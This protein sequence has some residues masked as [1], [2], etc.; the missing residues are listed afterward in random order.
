MR[1]LLHTKN[2]LMN[3]EIPGRHF[4]VGAYEA[5]TFADKTANFI[6]D[7]G[8]RYNLSRRVTFSQIPV[9]IQNTVPIP[10]FYIPDRF[11]NHQ[12]LRN[13]FQGRRPAER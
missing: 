4:D 1:E 7:C 6:R 3:L 5:L 9:A 2:G 12:T 8:T 10:Y 13:M 11:Y